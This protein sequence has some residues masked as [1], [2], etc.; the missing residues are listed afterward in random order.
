MGAMDQLTGPFQRHLCLLSAVL[1]GTVLPFFTAAPS[2]AASVPTY[3]LTDLGSANGC[4]VNGHRVSERKLAD[5]DRI[6]IGQ[7]EIAVT[8]M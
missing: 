2:V 8:I 5:G 1:L 4:T 7:N 6:G 3:V